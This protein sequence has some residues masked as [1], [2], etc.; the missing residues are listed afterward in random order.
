MA[1]IPWLA[2]PQ[3]DLLVGRDE[4]DRRRD[5]KTPDGNDRRR[6]N[7]TPSE[8]D[9]RRDNKTP[10]GNDSRLNDKVRGDTQ[11]APSPAQSLEVAK[12]EH[13]K[14]CDYCQHTSH[15]QHISTWFH[16][17]AHPLPHVSN[18]G[19]E[20]RAEIERLTAQIDVL[21]AASLPHAEKIRSH[22]LRPKLRVWARLASPSES[23][24][25]WRIFE[26]DR[27]M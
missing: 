4:N 8:N 22:R 1:W 26:R 6:D 13:R 25:L 20:K 3:P 9:R 2:P 23:G 19:P 10:G 14:S 21:E 24:W 12:S 17:Y 5:N 7:K 18:P 27:R 11:R 16:D 15:D